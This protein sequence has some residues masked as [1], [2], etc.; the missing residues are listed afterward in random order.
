MTFLVD[1]SDSVGAAGRQEAAAWVD[2]ALR[3]QPADARAALAMRHR[4]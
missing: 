1:G 2:E 4:G 3:T